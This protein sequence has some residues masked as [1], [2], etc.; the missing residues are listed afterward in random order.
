MIRTLITLSEE[1]KKWLDSYSHLQHQ[2]TAETIR[3]AIQTFHEEVNKENKK[4]LL[5]Q[6]SGLMKAHK[7]N[8]IDQI[9]E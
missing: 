5:S 2:S 6:T 1:D 7:K 8:S 9:R 3:Q 4:H